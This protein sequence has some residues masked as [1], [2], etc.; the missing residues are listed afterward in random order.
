MCA[1][2]KARNRSVKQ[3]SS[4][5]APDRPPFI[6]R[7]SD[8]PEIVGSYPNSS[9]K[10]SAGRAIGRTAGLLRI[11]LHIERLPSG[12]RTSW[13]H[14]ESLEEEFAYV[15][16]GEVD[17]WVDGTVH[18]M[19]AGDLAAFP[20]GTG[21]SHTFINNSDRDAVLFV[22]GEANKSD[23]RIVYPLA[24]QR[25]KQLPWSRWWHDAPLRLRG[26]HDGLPDAPDASART[27]RGPKVAKARAAAN[28]RPKI[29]VVVKPGK[30]KSATAKAKK[31]KP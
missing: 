25:A 9:E 23:N 6:L 30:A 31:V 7:S 12:T 18:R 19:T 3:V 29:T 13:P 26:P 17:C 20:S 28:V 15:L 1:M 16:E 21:I 4:S 8:V 27:A 22:G 5:N 24:P 11:G 14:A 10:L 2:A